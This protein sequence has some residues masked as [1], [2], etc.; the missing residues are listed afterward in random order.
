MLFFGERTAGGKARARNCPAQTDPEAP[1]N[2]ASGFGTAEGSM[3]FSSPS[4][5]PSSSPRGIDS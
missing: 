4:F 1:R 2:G 5:L 3:S